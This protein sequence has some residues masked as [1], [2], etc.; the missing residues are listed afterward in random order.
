MSFPTIIHYHLMQDFLLEKNKNKNKQTLHNQRKWNIGE[1]TLVMI[2][3]LT[4]YTVREESGS[5]QTN[6][7][8]HLN[9]DMSDI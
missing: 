2:H 3:F 1:W 9:Q 7:K 5:K 6:P 8:R 4:K